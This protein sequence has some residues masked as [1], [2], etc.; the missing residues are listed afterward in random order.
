M[1]GV[2]NPAGAMV[3]VISDSP[4]GPRYLLLHN[5]ET[6]DEGDWAWGSPSGCLEPGETIAECAARELFEETGIRAEPLPVITDDVDW[7][8]FRL[9]IP[10]GT[11][12]SLNPLE[13]KGF[14]WVTL[15]TARQRCRPERQRLSFESAVAAIE[16][17]G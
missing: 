12:V 2:R 4:N 3:A 9:R 7:A 16:G 5:A 10:W 8:V 1:S 6:T 11:P 17:S 13:H 14:E 15:A